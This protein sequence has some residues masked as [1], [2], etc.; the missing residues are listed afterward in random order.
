MIAQFPTFG[1]LYYYKD[2]I[3]TAPGRTGEAQTARVK[4][5]ELAKGPDYYKT[6]VL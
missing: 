2:L 4:A 6:L 5:D 3:L 1:F